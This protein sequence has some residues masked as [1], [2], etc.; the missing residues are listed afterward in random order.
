MYN[1]V[2]SLISGTTTVDEYG[3]ITTSETSRTVF[4]E[5]RSIGQKEFYE[6]HA[7]GLQPEIKF[8]LA[9]FYDYANEKIVEHNETRYHVLRTYRTENELEITCYTEVNH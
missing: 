1:D 8:V 5:V 3:D 6:A 2:I 4:C 7:T 9:D